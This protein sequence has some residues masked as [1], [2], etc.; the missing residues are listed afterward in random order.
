ME[1]HID[2]SNVQTSCIDYIS[3]EVEKLQSCS[4][5]LQGQI[6]TQFTAQVSFSHRWVH[7]WHIQGSDWTSYRFP[8]TALN[9][10][11]QLAHHIKNVAVA[12]VYF[13][14]EEE[15]ECN[16]NDWLC[17]VNL[18]EFCSRSNNIK[19]NAFSIST[20]SEYETYKCQM[21]SGQVAHSIPTC[22]EQK[23]KCNTLPPFFMSW[24]QRSQF[25]CGPFRSDIVI[26]V[27]QC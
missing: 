10:Q 15:H 14:V 21:I 8:A 17:S 20:H 6:G 1:Y 22:T 24:T 18:I 12:P 4:G 2:F 25:F 13:Y 27:N 26:C 16:K 19:T 9:E 3:N 11:P 23:Q 7:R 5:M